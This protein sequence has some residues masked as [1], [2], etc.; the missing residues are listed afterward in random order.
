[1]RVGTGHPDRPVKRTGGRQQVSGDVGGRDLM[2]RHRFVAECRVAPRG[3]HLG[4]LRHGSRRPRGSGAVFGI[5]DEDPR[6]NRTDF[7]PTFRARS[8]KRLRVGAGHPDRPVKWAKAVKMSVA[9]SA[10]ET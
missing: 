4:S 10:V 1:M 5:R 3:R 7:F 9:T 6:C 8:P 2:V